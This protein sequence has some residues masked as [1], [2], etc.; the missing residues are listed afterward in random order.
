MC[1][2]ESVCASSVPCMCL[3]R[4]VGFYRSL[5]GDRAKPTGRC[6]PSRENTE[7]VLKTFHLAPFVLHRPHRN[8]NLRAEKLCRLL[9]RRSMLCVSFQD[10]CHNFIKVLVPRNDDLVFICG[11]N[12]FNPMC[13]YY[14]VSIVLMPLMQFSLCT[15][16]Y[17]HPFSRRRSTK[18]L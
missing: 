17:M 1:E 6:A 10:E 2:R 11:T 13:R 8:F 4:H 5:H 15:R 12:G 3:M 16:F 9:R 7:C 18:L 14:R